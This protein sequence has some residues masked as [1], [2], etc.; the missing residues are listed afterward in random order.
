[1]KRNQ[2]SAAKPF[3]FLRHELLR[4]RYLQPGASP[5]FSWFL[6]GFGENPVGTQ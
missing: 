4:L 1:L 6:P 5:F 3:V 2:I